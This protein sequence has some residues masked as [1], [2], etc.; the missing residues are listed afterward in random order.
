MV[1]LLLDRGAQIDAKTKV[2][3]QLCCGAPKCPAVSQCLS[4]V[5]PRQDGLTPLHCAARS[6]HDRAVEILLDRG[7]PILARTKVRLRRIKS[8][9]R[10]ITS[11]LSDALSLFSCRRTDCPRCTCPPRETT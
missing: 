9:H 11:C 1:A 3:R 6:G 5:C 10:D 8:F 4:F 2:R 7:A